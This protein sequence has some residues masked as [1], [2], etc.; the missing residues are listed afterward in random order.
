MCN[1]KALCMKRS[2]SIS[3]T[4]RTFS[5]GVANGILGYPLLEGVDY[6]FILSEEP[7]TLEQVYAIVANVLKVVARHEPPPRVDPLPT[8]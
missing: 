2:H 6:R 1:P 4:F 8:E 3:G 5:Y 7:S